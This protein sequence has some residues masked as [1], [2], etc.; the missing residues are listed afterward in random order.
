MASTQLAP[1]CYIV[2]CSYSLQVV[3]EGVVD[4]EVGDDDGVRAYLP[5]SFGKHV[6]SRYTQ[7]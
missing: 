1:Y 3:V 7:L 2:L 6:V 4:D 5:M